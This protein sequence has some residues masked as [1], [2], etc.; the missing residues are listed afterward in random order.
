MTPRTR[1][2]LRMSEVRQRLKEIAALEDD[3][4]NDDLRANVDRLGTKCRDLVKEPVGSL[5]ALPRHADVR[6]PMQFA[7]YGDDLVDV[8]EPQ[9]VLFEAL[10]SPAR[11]G[12]AGRDQP[13]HTRTAVTRRCEAADTPHRRPPNAEHQRAISQAAR[14]AGTL[15]PPRPRTAP[16]AQGCPFSGRIPHSQRHQD[17]QRCPGEVDDRVSDPVLRPAGEV[18]GRRVAGKGCVRI[19]RTC[20][21]RRSVCQMTSC[22]SSTALT[23]PFRGG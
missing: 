9:H 21:T 8:D 18:G 10:A 7:P 19:I 4:F 20:R 22:P 6:R 13:S 1:I 5:A 14:E 11:R 3:D 15:A 17:G 12:D 23:C 2:E 16:S